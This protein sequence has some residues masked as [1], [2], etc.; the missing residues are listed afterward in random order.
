MAVTLS[1]GRPP[2]RQ[3]K[4]KNKNRTEDIFAEFRDGAPKAE[5]IGERLQ[6]EETE[7]L[8]RRAKEPRSISTGQKAVSAI[9]GIPALLSFLSIFIM[10]FF[11][12]DFLE[13]N[14]LGWVMPAMF[15]ITFF[16]FGLLILVSARTPFGLIF[17][18]VG[19]GVAGFAGAYGLGSPELQ[20][21]LM[22]SVIPMAALALFPIAGM[23]VM[24]GGLVQKANRK[25]KYTLEV[26]ARIVDKQK[27]RSTHRDSD[28]THTST[29]YPL[30]WKYTVNGQEYAWRANMSRSPEKRNIGDSG[31]LLV[32][33]ADPKDAYDPVIGK[34]MVAFLVVFGAV[35]T[36]AGIFGIVSLLSQMHVL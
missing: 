11:G 15:G 6:R 13:S 22:Q 25:K 5:S 34:G 3:L 16:L 36:A 14:D 10:G 12:M 1:N 2:Q 24:I 31:T 21:R 28:G 7:E 20:D 27:I 33:P 32:N 9:I 35:F 17:V 23:G 30:T 18:I 4:D 26:Q 29:T 8:R 19:G